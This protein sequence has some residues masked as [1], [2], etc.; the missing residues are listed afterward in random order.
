M[1]LQSKRV[2]NSGLSVPDFCWNHP[3]SSSADSAC[4]CSVKSAG[5]QI[6]SRE[7]SHCA[8]TFFKAAEIHGIAFVVC[9]LTQEESLDS[10]G[11]KNDCTPELFYESMSLKPDVRR[12]HYQWVIHIPFCSVYSGNEEENPPVEFVCFNN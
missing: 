12:L 11:S 10:K 9:C 7:K 1:Q 8:E 4:F 5:T 6:I 3:F 2:S